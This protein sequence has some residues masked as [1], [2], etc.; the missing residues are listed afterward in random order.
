MHPHSCILLL[1]GAEVPNLPVGF[2][3]LTVPATVLSPT[4]FQQVSNFLVTLSALYA[5]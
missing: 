3:N 4:L 1:H 5:A 2:A